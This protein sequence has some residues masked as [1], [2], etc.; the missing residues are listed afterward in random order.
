M[1]PEQLREQAIRKAKEEKEE[2]ERLSRIRIR[3]NV[4]SQ[5]YNKMHQMM[6]SYQ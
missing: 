3:D 1:T 6:L 2:E 5:H 4:N